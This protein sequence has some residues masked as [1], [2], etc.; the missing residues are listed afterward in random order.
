M[1]IALILIFF[2]GNS[3][4]WADQFEEDLKAIKSKYDVV[5]KKEESTK[6]S[7]V[8][9]S[10]LEGD[11]SEKVDR[12]INRADLLL[13]FEYFFFKDKLDDLAK[14][15]GEM[16]QVGIDLEFIFNTDSL[17]DV[18]FY[19]TYG[20]TSNAT[21]V[22]TSNIY[23][24]PNTFSLGLG[25][26]WTRGFN[27]INPFFAVEFEALSS[28]GVDTSKT[29]TGDEV[30]NYMRG[31]SIK[32]VNLL[33]GLDHPFYLITRP[34]YLRAYLGTALYGISQLNQSDYE[35]KVNVFKLGTNLKME[36]VDHI[37][38][39]LGWKG[40]VITGSTNSYLSHFYL[41]LGYSF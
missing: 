8:T 24:T 21:F 26:Y 18:L 29:F 30:F 35:E 32:S 13:N 31:N 27:M 22:G 14:I 15:N 23:D 40:E 38:L 25:P 19:A 12:K 7:E 5:Y 17:L 36:F 20:F 4:V 11:F 28:V 10:D 1:K 3:S 9:E 39:T 16:T 33:L 41:N 6:W 34:T 2:L 37:L